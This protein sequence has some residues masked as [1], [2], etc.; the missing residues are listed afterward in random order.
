MHM[1][2][3]DLAKMF[4]ISRTRAHQIVADVERTKIDGK[5]ML[6]KRREIDEIDGQ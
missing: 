2:L 3:E 1:S 4:E 6:R 5:W